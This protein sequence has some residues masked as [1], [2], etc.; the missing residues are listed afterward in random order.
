MTTRTRWSQSILLRTAAAVVGVAFIVGILFSARAMVVIGER[1]QAH[2]VAG[3]QELLDTVESTVSI[4]CLVQD[5]SLASEVARGLLKNSSVL[6][7]VIKTDD[8]DLARSF[9]EAAIP[10]DT[11]KPTPRHLTRPI[12]APFGVRNKVGEIELYP[13]VEQSESDVQRDVRFVAMLLLMQLGAVVAA[14]VVVVL[15][16]VV[17]PIKGMSDTLHRMDASA[18]D[19]LPMPVGHSNTEVGRLAGDINALADQLVSSLDDERRSRVRHEMDE[20]KYRGIFDHAETGIFIA[21]RE[22]VI[23]SANPALARLLGLG[24]DVAATGNDAD[25]T[26]LNWNQPRRLPELIAACLASNLLHED[27]LELVFAGGRTRWLHLVLT[28]IG[29]GMIQGL[30]S[31][32]TERK[33][34]EDKARTQAVTDLLTGAANRFGFE[35]RLQLELRQAAADPNKVGFALMHIDLDH[36]KRVNEA[37]GLPAGDAV[38]KLAVERL[39]KTLKP[40]DTVA[41]LGGDEFAVILPG[42]AGEELAAR[43]GERLVRALGLDF[44]VDATPIKLGAS[45]G[46]TLFPGDGRDLPTLM[47]N[48]E[49]ALHRAAYTGGS[50]YSFFDQALAD[51]AE[52]RQAMEADMQRALLRGEFRLFY[53]PI[54]DIGANRLVGAEALIRWFHHANGLVPPDAFIPLAEET[55]LIVDIGLWVLENA[56]RQLAAWQAAGRDYYVSLNISGRQIPDGLPPSAVADAIRRHGLDPARLV[57]EI[58]E[59]VLMKDV[60]LAQQWLGAVRELGCRVYLDDF[61]TGFS[62]L[63][64]LKR[65]P[66]NTVKVDKSFV[67]D[68]RSDSSDRALVEA[69]VVMAHSLGMQVI[70]EGVENPAQLELL[71][72]LNCGCVQGF[73]FSWPVPAEEFDAAAARVQTLLA[74]TD[75]RVEFLE[76]YR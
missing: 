65:F 37:L 69:I 10:P 49:L 6:G 47:R 34:A 29:Q 58:T 17:R 44:H 14:I 52:Q 12:Y 72:Q 53:Q 28:H 22:G 57:L 9:R 71:R 1:T 63:S 54:V 36:F 31:D 7:V 32:V 3:L 62:S 46:I 59:G 15:R 51:S 39:R 11:A 8:K 20:K 74:R 73:Y 40:T 43:I 60:G 13:D 38:L 4:A 41:R 61:G 66:V 18:G 16:W 70:A 33:L 75:G 25:I 68:M 55:G 24:V 23:E 48:A 5:A 76:E 64:Y 42:V 27:D 50:R 30:A 21:N 2:T 19:R 67:R 45:I 56:C 26:G 35:E